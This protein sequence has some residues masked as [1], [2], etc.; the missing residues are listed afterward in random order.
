MKQN[1]KACGQALVTAI[2]NALLALA[3]MLLLEFA[4]S[5]SFQI[6]EAYVW[7]V[8]VIGLVIFFAQFWRQRHLCRDDNPDQ[9]ENERTT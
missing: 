8:A 7:A 5:G 1:L 3:L 9:Y 4:I 6:A 2:I